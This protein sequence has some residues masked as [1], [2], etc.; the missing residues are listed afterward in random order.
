MGLSKGS[1]YVTFKKSH[2]MNQAM[3]HLDGAQVDGNFIKATFVLVSNKRRREPSPGD[4]SNT[5]LHAVFCSTERRFFAALIMKFLS[6]NI[7][8]NRP[9]NFQHALL[10]REEVHPLQEEYGQ[11]NVQEDREIQTGIP[12]ISQIETSTRVEEE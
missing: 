9:T 7:E 10:Q 11:M 6:T 3:L 4:S 2:D 1:A 12:V 5:S 8:I